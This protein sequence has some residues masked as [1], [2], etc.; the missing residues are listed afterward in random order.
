MSDD[1]FYPWQGKRKGRLPSPC[2]LI[3]YA[4][5][6]RMALT[7]S[8]IFLLWFSDVAVPVPTRMNA[9]VVL[10]VEVVEEVQ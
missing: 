8:D 3:V 10:V 9:A 4:S 2:N 1:W 5:C 7:L 6:C